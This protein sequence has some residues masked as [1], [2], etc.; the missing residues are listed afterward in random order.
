MST[1]EKMFGVIEQWFNSGL[2]KKQFLIDHQISEATFNYW[3]SKWKLRQEREKV[4]F[5]SIN[6]QDKKSKKCWNF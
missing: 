6:L 5:E 3:I 4:G 2:T 1:Q